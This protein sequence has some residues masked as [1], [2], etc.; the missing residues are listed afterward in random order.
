MIDDLPAPERVAF[1]PG[2]TCLGCRLPIRDGVL[3]S[4]D[5]NLAAGATLCCLGCGL[6]QITDD[7]RTLRLPTVEEQ[8]LILLRLWA[9]L[10][11]G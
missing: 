11:D 6:I 4:G 10:G 5:V 3:C 8:W 2:W 9:L 7:G 1:P